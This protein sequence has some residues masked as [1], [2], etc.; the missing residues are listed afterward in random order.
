[1]A[2]LVKQWRVNP[3][4]RAF[5]E[6]LIADV[7]PKDTRGEIGAVFNFVRDAIRYTRD[8][9]DVEMLKAPDVLLA[10]RFGDCDDKA[11]LL[12][13][14]LETVGYK[15][16]FVAVGLRTE[17]FEHVYVEVLLGDPRSPQSWYALDTTEP[18]PMGWSPYDGAQPIKA[19]MVW[20]V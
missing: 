7:P 5:A 6:T 10:E 19:R 3:D 15:T 9:N 11:T 16:R 12:A 14:L 2:K 4:M 1:M 17:D 8:I 13:T 18:H 20:H